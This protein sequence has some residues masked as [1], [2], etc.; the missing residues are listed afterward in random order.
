M[1][2]YISNFCTG[3]PVDLLRKRTVTAIKETRRKYTHTSMMKDLE[4]SLQKSTNCK[5]TQLHIHLLHMCK[6]SPTEPTNCILY[7]S[8][9][10]VLTG[11]KRQL[12]MPTHTKGLIKYNHLHL[13]STISCL[14]FI[15]NIYI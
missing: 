3:K 2:T 9:T 10:L 14:W 8:Q 5:T 4:I 15:Q 6:S 13:Q 1:T 7:N 12:C 11:N